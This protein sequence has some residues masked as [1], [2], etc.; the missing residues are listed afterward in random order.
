[1]TGVFLPDVFKLP[2]ARKLCT[3]C[4]DVSFFFNFAVFDLSFKI[5]LRKAVF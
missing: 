1:M 2:E 4:M 5:V 3:V